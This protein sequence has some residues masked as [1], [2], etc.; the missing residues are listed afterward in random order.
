MV[1]EHHLGTL[2]RPGDPA[3]LA[4][5]VRDLVRDHAEHLRSV[6]QARSLSWSHDAAVLVDLHDGLGP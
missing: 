6:R 3:D 1:R 4:R 5:A 2:Y